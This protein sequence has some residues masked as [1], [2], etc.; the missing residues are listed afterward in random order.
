MILLMFGQAHPPDFV[1]FVCGFV[2]AG[3]GVGTS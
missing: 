2:D 1:R 3:R